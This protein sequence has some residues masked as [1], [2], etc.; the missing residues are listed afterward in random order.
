M[1][2]DE[3][4]KVTEIVSAQNKIIALICLLKVNAT[5]FD[6]YIIEVITERVSS[7]PALWN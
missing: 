7:K 5:L 4:M 6:K 2:I 1:E 3:L